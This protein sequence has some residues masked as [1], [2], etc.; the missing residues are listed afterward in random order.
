MQRWIPSFNRATKLFLRERP[1]TRRIFHTS[2]IFATSIP[3]NM[4][5]NVIWSSSTTSSIKLLSTVSVYMSYN[6]TLVSKIY[7]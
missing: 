3:S 7:E 5:F 6:S 1:P 2:T 4:V